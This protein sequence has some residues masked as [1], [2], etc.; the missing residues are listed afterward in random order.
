ML[1]LSIKDI[2]VV[3]F[4]HL[5]FLVGRVEEGRG[6]KKASAPWPLFTQMERK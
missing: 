6:S 2:S 1:V 3:K 4:T 5:F